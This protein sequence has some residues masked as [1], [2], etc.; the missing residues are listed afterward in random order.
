V[1]QTPA[2]DPADE[3]QALT[4]RADYLNQ[5][6]L[7]KS[8]MLEPEKVSGPE[9]HIRWYERRPIYDKVTGKGFSGLALKIGGL[10][11]GSGFAGGLNYHR[12]RQSGRAHLEATALISTKQFK[13]GQIELMVPGPENDPPVS[14]NINAEYQDYT[15]RRFFGLGPNSDVHRQTFYRDENRR[16]GVSLNHES[17]WFQ[18]SAGAMILNGTTRAGLT[19][20]STDTVFGPDRVPGVGARAE[21]IAPAGHV[22]LRLLDYGYPPLGVTMGF[23]LQHYADQRGNN[24]SFSRWTG[25]IAG[26]IPLGVRSRRLALHARTSHSLPDAESEVPFQLMETIGGARSIRGFLEYRFRD[27]R[28]LLLSA[29][30]RWEIWTFADWVFFADA[31]KVFSEGSDLNFSDLETS[32]GTGLRIHAPNDFVVVAQF[33]KS[34][35][36]YAIHLGSG[37]RF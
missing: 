19:D 16:L 35:E 8:V 29:E 17:H 25:E 14:V 27:T 5:L 37:P 26:Y 3:P 32:Y 18:A 7:A 11:S 28:N 1:A 15:D 21:W 12:G 9:K 4:T 24:L 20:P 36:T 23:G 2:T 6:R 31:G 30:Y 34:K 33:A 22:E 10:P 13:R